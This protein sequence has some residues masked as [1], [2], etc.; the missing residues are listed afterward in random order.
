MNDPIRI[1]LE[2]GKKKRVVA[3][4][5]DWPGW[6]RSTKLGGDVLVVLDARRLAASL[7]RA[8]D[9]VWTRVTR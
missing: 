3:S 7:S 9:A 4:A 5:F 8:S 1:M 2:H 6:D